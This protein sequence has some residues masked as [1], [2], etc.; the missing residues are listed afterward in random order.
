[1]RR[2][3]QADRHPPRYPL[4][5]DIANSVT[6]GIGAL[7]SLL[8]TAIL[9]Y[10]AAS[11]DGTLLHWVSFAIYGT[12]LVLLHVSSTLYHALRAPAAR[13]ALFEKH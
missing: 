12:T 7:L 1:M 13:R 9:L 2:T 6:H 10:R 11:G 5:E 3:T 4:G 8:G